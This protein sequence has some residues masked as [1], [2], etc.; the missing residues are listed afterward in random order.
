M[1]G[2]KPIV[3]LGCGWAL[4]LAG[5]LLLMD[6]CVRYRPDNPARAALESTGGFAIVVVGWLLRRVAIAKSRKPGNG[7]GKE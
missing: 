6:A 4:M 2:G 1:A 5:A 3:M 7:F